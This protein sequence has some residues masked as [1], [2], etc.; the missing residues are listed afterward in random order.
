MMKTYTEDS[1]PVGINKCPTHKT[2][3]KVRQ[4]KGMHIRYCPYCDMLAE[5]KKQAELKELGAVQ[6]PNVKIGKL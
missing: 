6:K 5:Q 1:V 3:I 4:Q 2:W